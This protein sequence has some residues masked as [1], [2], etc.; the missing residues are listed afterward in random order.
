[1]RA[2]GLVIVSAMVFALGVYGGYIGANI[3]GMASQPPAA[4]AASDCGAEEATLQARVRSLEDEQA[5]L[6]G[7]LYERY[8]AAGEA[9]MRHPEEALP[10]IS[11]EALAKT[12]FPD[13]RQIHCGEYPCVAVMGVRLS[14]AQLGKLADAGIEPTIQ[15]ADGLYAVVLTAEGVPAP[16]RTAK[17]V[18]AMLRVLAR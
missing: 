12:T 7:T 16:P 17:R 10:P 13:L 2:L 1:M 18:D 14:E 5:K 15:E 4:P 8:L 3:V 9:P 11:M 6:R